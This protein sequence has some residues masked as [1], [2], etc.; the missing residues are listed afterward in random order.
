MAAHDR[1][2]GA[3]RDPPRK[4]PAKPESHRA[5]S[6]ALPKGG[7]ALRAIDEKFSVNAVNGTSSLAIPL[8]FSHARGAAPSLALQY[9]SGGGN[10]PFALGWSIDLPSIQRRTDKRLP[11]Y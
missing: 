4:Q 2:D 11:R 9:G 7:G 6:I 8:P 1:H 10:G 3:T 5:P